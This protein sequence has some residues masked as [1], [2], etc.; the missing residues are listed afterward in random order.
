LPLAVVFGG[1]QQAVK[2]PLMIPCHAAPS[3]Q[4]NR[5]RTLRYHNVVRTIERLG[6]WAGAASY[7]L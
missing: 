6:R 1:R 5:G 4:E 7:G 2:L 3:W